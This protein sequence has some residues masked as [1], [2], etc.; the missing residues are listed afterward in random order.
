MAE[1]PTTYVDDEEIDERDDFEDDDEGE[2]I[3]EQTKKELENLNNSDEA[4]KL[5]DITKQESEESSERDSM[6]FENSKEDSDEDDVVKDEQKDI[7]ASS[8]KQSSD[9]FT[10][11]SS[12]RSRLTNF[13]PLSRTIWVNFARLHQRRWWTDVH[14]VKRK[15]RKHFWAFQRRESKD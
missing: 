15:R 7:L 9:Q 2:E 13:R 1:E 11:S 12:S 8:G 4:A 14:D 5:K 10:Y 3:D 6:S